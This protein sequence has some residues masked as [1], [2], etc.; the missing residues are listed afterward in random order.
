MGLPTSGLVHHVPIS[1]IM[2]SNPERNALLSG[3]SATP[4]RAEIIT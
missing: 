2:L 3:L 1:D 4:V